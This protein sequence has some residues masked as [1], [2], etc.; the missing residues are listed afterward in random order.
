MKMKDGRH[1]ICFDQYI[2]MHKFLLTAIDISY[3]T[4]YP[5]QF[6]PIITINY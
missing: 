2:R 1:F 3:I 4:I 6:H 5:L